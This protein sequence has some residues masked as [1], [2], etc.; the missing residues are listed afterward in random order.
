MTSAEG[1]PRRGRR[2]RVLIVGEDLQRDRID[3]ALVQPAKIAHNL[4]EAIGEV[5]S[6]GAHDP[7]A[8]VILAE[9]FT[10]T[11]H[12]T[13]I[14]ALRRV[15]PS[16]RIVAMSR[17]IGAAPVATQPTGGPRWPDAWLEPTAGLDE[18]RRAL[19]DDGLVV[20]PASFSASV[21]AAPGSARSAAAASAPVIADPPPPIEIPPHA[22]TEQVST[23]SSALAHDDGD[24]VAMTDFDASPPAPAATSSPPAAL[25]SEPIPAVALPD[26]MPAPTPAGAIGDTDLIHALLHG[27]AG[28]TPLALR[29]I[30]DYGGWNDVRFVTEQADSIAAASADHSVEVLCAGRRLGYLHAAGAPPGQLRAWADWLG[31]WL[32]MEREHRRLMHESNCDDL[33]GAWNRRFF[34][35]FLA[36]AIAQARI[37]RRPVT[38]MVFDI[39]NFK[40][41]N[42]AHG[43]DAGDEVL[44]ETVRLLKSIVRQGD[45]VCRMGGDEFVVVFADPEAPRT[46]GSK[47]PESVETIA[48]RFQQ[49][50]CSMRFPKLGPEAQGSLSISAGLATFP[51]D[52]QDAA[53]LLRHADQLAMQSKR[54]G[55]NAITIGR[56]ADDQSAG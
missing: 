15:D 45:I 33:T 21:D 32:H 6:S 13:A 2:G 3:A 28:V 47:H 23:Q 51:W 7:I 12:A 55:K 5:A 25:P 10:R 37:D 1:R 26:A 44:R 52:G 22:T 42:D 50:V 16:L 30:A 54:Y 8:A 41:Y 36:N 38:V 20:S 49:A 35:S 18:L 29:L 11:P 27:T 9:M 24:A 40:H 43:H 56:H 17:S 39:D 34:D 31:H 19:D 46:P 53:S 48:R 4:F 14:E